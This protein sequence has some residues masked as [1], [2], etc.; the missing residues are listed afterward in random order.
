MTP[1]ITPSSS[2]IQKF[3]LSGDSGNQRSASAIGE[4][5]TSTPKTV[6]FSQTISKVFPKTRRELLP[7]D[8]ITEEKEEDDETQFDIT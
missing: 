3:L 6:S 7:L 4:T 8:S 1:P 5:S 2:S